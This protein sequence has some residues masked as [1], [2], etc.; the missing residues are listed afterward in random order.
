[1]KRYSIVGKRGLMC[2]AEISLMKGVRRGQ[3]SS[4]LRKLPKGKTDMKMID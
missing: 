2:F 3:K 4:G 1:M